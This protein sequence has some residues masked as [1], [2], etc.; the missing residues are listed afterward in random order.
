MS[1]NLRMSNIRSFAD[2]NKR[3]EKADDDV[4]YYAGGEK[5]YNWKFE[6]EKD[7][8]DEIWVSKIKN[9]Q[10]SDIWLYWNESKWI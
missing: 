8:I 1:L 5:R 3:E 7:K 9:K 10:I 4:E 2:I 6:R